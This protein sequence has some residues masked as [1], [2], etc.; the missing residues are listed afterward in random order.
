MSRPRQ[1]AIA[2]QE[3]ACR[4]RRIVLIL[5]FASLLAGC[6]PVPLPS[7]VDSARSPAVRVAD[8]PGQGQLPP[9]PLAPGE[10]VVIISAEF[11]DAFAEGVRDEVAQQAPAIPVLPETEFR[12]ALFPWFQSGWPSGH[13]EAFERAMREQAVRRKIE[14]LDLRY[15][16]EV[17]GSTE[18]DGQFSVG[19][20]PGAM[21]WA[22]PHTKVA[23]KV[24]DL[25]KGQTFQDAAAETSGI[26]FLFWAVYGVYLFSMTESKATDELAT[27]LVLFFE[28]KPPPPETP[29]PRQ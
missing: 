8:V 12:R 28:G 5:G 27:R 25:R 17:R 1:S 7:T 2:Q 6:L 15:L 29:T 23:A 3:A 14:E 16:V 21:G 18:D 26:Q 9:R 20:Y 13:P 11:D 10:K 24:W 22:T 19:P 4:A